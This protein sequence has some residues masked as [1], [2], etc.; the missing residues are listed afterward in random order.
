MKIGR[1][2]D[3]KPGEFKII[4]GTDLARM[5]GVIPGEKVNVMVPQGQFTPAGTMPR[6]RQFTVAGVFNSGHYEFDSAMSFI[7]LTDAEKLMR[8]QTPEAFD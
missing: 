2:S 1:L 3:L 6:M 5:L 4:L 8:T 7:N